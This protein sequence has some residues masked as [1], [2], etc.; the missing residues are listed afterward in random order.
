MADASMADFEEELTKSFRVIREGDILKGVIVDIDDEAVTLDLGYYAPGVVPLLEL[1]DDPDFSAMKELKIGDTM[2]AVVLQ[3]DDGKGNVELSR[4]EANRQTAWEKLNSLM[5]EET[6]VT[7]KV[8]ESVNQ[9]VVAYLEGIRAF[10]PASQLAVGFVEDTAEYV[11]R[12]LSVKV[13]TV[14]ER[15]EKLVLSAKAVLKEQEE[16]QNRRKMA[17]ITPGSVFEGTVESLMPYGAFVQLDNGLTG[18]VHISKISMK[19]I[20]KPSEVLSVGQRVKVKVLQVKDGKISL[21]IRDVEMN[22]SDVV[23][24]TVEEFNYQDEEIPNNPFSALLAG[25]QLDN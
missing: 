15:K 22:T 12:Q 2:E 4:K 17:M 5:Q 6:V 18:L 13:I 16:E 25:I 23:T 3:T 20:G 21:S 7:V 8:R 19:R 14:D 11:G 24:E 9:G 10:I 1:S